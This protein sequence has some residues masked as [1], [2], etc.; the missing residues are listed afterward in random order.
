ME[1]E[2]AALANEIDMAAHAE[3]KFWSIVAQSEYDILAGVLHRDL[4][5]RSADIVES[6]HDLYRRIRTRR[7]WVHVED[8]ARAVL[9]PYL[10]VLGADQGAERQAAQRVLDLLAGFVATAAGIC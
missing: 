8:D 2:L 3:P 4:A 9:E 7:Y 6:M 10:A 1:C 5:A